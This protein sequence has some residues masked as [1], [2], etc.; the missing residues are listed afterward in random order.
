MC[1]CV[2]IHIA[3]WKMTAYQEISAVTD[4]LT[5]DGDSTQIHSCISQVSI[6]PNMA[7]TWSVTVENA[8]THREGRKGALDCHVGHAREMGPLQTC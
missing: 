4:C 6:S 7:Y 3:P 1:V 2:K 5:T 8:H